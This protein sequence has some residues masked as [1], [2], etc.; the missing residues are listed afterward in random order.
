MLNVMKYKA[1]VAE[2]SEKME[3]NLDE[4]VILLLPEVYVDL[5]CGGRPARYGLEIRLVNN[6]Y[7]SRQNWEAYSSRRANGVGCY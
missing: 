2:S 6:R 4:N 1:D 7:L 3:L 5:N